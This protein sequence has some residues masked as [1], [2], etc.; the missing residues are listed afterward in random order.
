MRGAVM[1][2]RSS[3]NQPKRSIA[4]A[5]PRLRA[6]MVPTSEDDRHDAGEGERREDPR[7][8]ANLSHHRCLDRARK[9][10]YNRERDRDRRHC[11]G[12]G[13]FSSLWN[14]L[15]S[16]PSL[17]LQ[18]ANQPMLGIGCFSPASP[19]SSFTFAR[20]ASMSSLPR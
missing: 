7:A 9:P 3:P 16:L 2:M 13:A 5:V 18:P 4:A 14:R 6:M 10:G 15:N 19:P 8:L 12:A 1:P 17:S 11:C 20:S